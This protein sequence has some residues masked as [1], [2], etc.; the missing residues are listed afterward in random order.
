M[1]LGALAL[2]L[3]G[4]GL[5]LAAVMPGVPA[6][7]GGSIVLAVGVAFMTP[8]LF[9]ATFNAVP[10][11]ERGAAAGTGTLFI[12]LGFGAGP[13]LAGFVAADAGIPVAFAAAGGVAIIAAVATALASL[14]GRSAAST[15]G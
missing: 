15:T 13:L 5:L 7:L 14:T 8:A 3:V 4:I 1:V 10:P 2:A 9:A 12:D 6:L 11:T